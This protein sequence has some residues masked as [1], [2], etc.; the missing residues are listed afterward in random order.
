M[1]I[2]AAQRQSRPGATVIEFA[3]L[4]PLLAFLFV[5]GV[6]FARVYFQMI[7]VENAASGGALWGA[8]DEV[9]AADTEGI[10]K[11]ALTDC[12]DLDPLPT[13][14]SVRGVDGFKHPY[15]KVTVSWTFTTVS[16]F[17]LVPN[18]VVLSRTVQM[19][20]AP[21]QPKDLP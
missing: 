7:T 13:V 18:T 17:P 12:T 2:R 6:D 21:T 10:K 16:R 9:R 4:L 3:V 15:L 1:A 19:R 11:A 5:A 14:T 20:I 8:R